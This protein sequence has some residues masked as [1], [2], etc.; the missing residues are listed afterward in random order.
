VP[1][2]QSYVLA[3]VQPSERTMASGVTNVTRNLAWAI[4]P[5]VAG[6]VMQQV[7]LAGPLIIGGTL[8]IAYDL[9]L[10]R[11]FQH[12]RPPEEESAM[13]LPR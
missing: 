6:S 1:T 2:R 7:A 8:K 11:A 12:V 10:Y 3:I 9:L 13:P 5:A 4:G